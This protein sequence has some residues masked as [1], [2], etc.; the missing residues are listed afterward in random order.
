M[1]RKVARHSNSTTAVAAPAA[2]DMAQ[3]ACGPISR[4][5]HTQAMSVGLS[6]CQA[7]ELSHFQ[8]TLTGH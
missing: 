3:W 6:R 5:M 4:D 2:A 1:C 8:V 7:A